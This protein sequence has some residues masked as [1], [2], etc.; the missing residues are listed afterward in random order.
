M[1]AVLALTL[2]AVS[3]ASGQPRRSSAQPQWILFTATPPGVGVQQVFRITMSGK[4]LKQLTKGAYPADAPAFSPNAKRIAF[5][6]LGAGIFSMN[7]DGTGLRRLTTNGRDSLPAWSPDGKQIAFIRPFASGWKVHVMS[8][9]GAGERRLRLAPSAGRP[10]WTAGGLV[11][12]T[13][14]GDLAKIDPRSG[15]VAKRFGALIDVSVG[16]TGAAVSPDL[17]TVTFVGS[18]PP[19]P[20][21]KDCGE[22]VPCPRFALYIEDLRNHKAPRL[23]ARDAGPASFS[24][25]GKSLAFVARNRIVLRLLK[26]GTSR[27]VA[28][29]KSSPTTGTPPAWQPR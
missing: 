6:R 14:D 10:S 21:D 9:S 2:T 5:A 22:G 20:G 4:G 29:G 12:P 18:R 16:L 27:A 13:A 28:T 11:I 8:A 24:P 1:I 17:S 25:D 23:L 19:N 3:A 26:N 7:L 15:R